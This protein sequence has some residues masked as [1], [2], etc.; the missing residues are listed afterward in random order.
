MVSVSCCVLM[1]FLKLGNIP[2]LFLIPFALFALTLASL[3][4]LIVATRSYHLT[5]L[6]SMSDCFFTV[7]IHFFR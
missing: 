7:A 2:T 6:V 5:L 1:P 4:F 3:L